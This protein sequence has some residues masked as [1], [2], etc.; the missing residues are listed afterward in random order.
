ME[1]QDITTR[2]FQSHVSM[3]DG[4]FAIPLTQIEFIYGRNG[5]IDASGAHA[6]PHALASPDTLVMDEATFKATTD[7]L[8]NKVITDFFI[9]RKLCKTSNNL[10]GLAARCLRPSLAPLHLPLRPTL[11]PT[12]WRMHLD[13][14]EEARSDFSPPSPA[15]PAERSFRFAP[16]RTHHRASLHGP[17]PLSLS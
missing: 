13:G 12:S 17:R 3:P 14:H 15:R 16:S 9:N 11:P 8:T 6:V 1:A 7:A 2:F 4:T 10:P 5:M